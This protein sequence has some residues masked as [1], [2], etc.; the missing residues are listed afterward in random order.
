MR[1]QERLE[2]AVRGVHDWF[3]VMC[4]PDLESIANAVRGVAGTRAGRKVDVDALTRKLHWHVS[5][6]ALGARDHGTKAALIPRASGGFA[7]IV[8]PERAPGDSGASRARAE[9]RSLRL[10]HELGHALFYKPTCPPRRGSAPDA[11][12]EKFC[13]AFAERLIAIPSRRT[14]S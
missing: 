6:R 10:A 3:G 1:D 7:I 13:D 11:G 12:E 14:P 8:D 2:R 4:A 5:H 9:N